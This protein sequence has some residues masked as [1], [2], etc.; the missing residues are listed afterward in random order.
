MRS[1]GPSPLLV[2]S[3]IAM[4]CEMVRDRSGKA[5]LGRVC[6]VS[7]DESILLDSY[8]QVPHDEI[9]DYLTSVSGLTRRHLESAPSFEHVQ[10]QVVQL[11]EGQVLI[12][13]AIA[14]DLKALQ[15]SHPAHL[16][17]DTLELDWGRS[18]RKG[19]KHLAH[20]V[21]GC[22]EQRIDGFVAGGDTALDR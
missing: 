22:E 10:K 13:H 18:R 2:T 7:W 17:L 21:L 8:V 9:E 1:S 20:E 11:C 3:A 16:L 6:I 12:G 5:R 14:N 4:D 15:L 19:L